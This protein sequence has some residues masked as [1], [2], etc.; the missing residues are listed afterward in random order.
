MKIVHVVDYFQPTLG[1]QEVFLAKEQAK[2]GHEVIVVT[3]NRYAPVLYVNK[4]AESILGSRIRRS[5]FFIEE[6]IK[7]WR[8]KT[9]FEFS[10]RVWMIGLAKKILELKPD[11][12][13][14]DG[15]NTISALRISWLKL[16][17]KKFRN[18]RLIID[19]HLNPEGSMSKLKFMY[20]L[21]KHTTLKLVNQAVDSFIAVSETTREFMFQN[22]GISF[23]RI[24]IIPLGADTSL[25]K[26][27]S[28]ARQEIRNKLKITKNDVV[29][30]YTGK[31]IPFKYLEILI[32][33]AFELMKKYKNIK[34]L[35]VG[36]SDQQYENQ[37]RSII[38]LKNLEECFIWQKA[39]PN[40]ELY[41]YFS[42]ADVAVWPHLHTNSI[43]EAMACGLP[44]I[45]CDE[46]RSCEEV[47]YNNGLIYRDLD[48]KDLKEKMEQ[49]YL[50]EDLRKE[51][52]NNALEI[53][54]K[55]YNWSN[56]AKEFI[57]EYENK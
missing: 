10:S 34:V 46:S 1:Y 47:K 24:K 55:R 16:H 50:N 39:V 49:L 30:I 42:A 5:G 15:V 13:N 7:V 31:I 44:V 43:L 54:Q 4:A 53:V 57:K 52:G 56:I 21:L 17:N 25:F 51:L 2:L 11:V 37:L 33:S 45:V 3:S 14:I 40:K 9:L 19:D 38:K 6:D 29:Y 35:F 26:Y 41:K 36:Y 22:Y 20:P 32:E 18:I 8:L 27:D 48:V 12:I 23:D 28:L